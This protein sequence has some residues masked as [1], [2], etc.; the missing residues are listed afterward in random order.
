MLKILNRKT[1]LL[2]AAVIV[3]ATGAS[4]PAE[5]QVTHDFSYVAKNMNDSISQLPGLLTGI[6]YM[7][8]LLFGCLGILKIKDHVENASQTPL[9]DGAI[10][11]ASGGALFALPI[12]F[13]AMKTTIGN[14]QAASVTAAP[15]NRA[16]F[17]VH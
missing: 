2:Q 7:M 12:V 11:L 13:E 17:N 6:A 1:L 8:G 14:D 10:R 9:K 4:I 15:L 5:A 3:G 16:G